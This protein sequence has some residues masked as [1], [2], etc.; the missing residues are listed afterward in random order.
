MEPRQPMSTDSNQKTQQLHAERAPRPDT[1]SPADR[2][3]ELFVAV[4]SGPVFADSKTF[5][6]CAPVGEPAAILQAYR[7][8]FRRPDF[9]LAAFVDRHFDVTHP[10]KSEYQSEPGQGLCAHIDSLWPVLTRDPRQHAANASMLHLPEP[11]VVPGG[12]FGEMYYWDSYFTMV[13]LAA[14]E[15]TDL[16][17]AMLTNFSYLID[18]YGHVPNGTRSYYLSRS[19][20][21]VFALMLELAEQHGVG[22]AANHRAQ[23]QQE[24]AYWMAGSSE[25]SNLAEIADGQATRRVVRLPNGLQ[26]NRYWDDRDTPREESWIEDV[27]TAQSCTRDA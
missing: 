2:Y 13:G 24:H 15:R 9:E 12:R 21:P 26:L 20:P 5:V 8:Q 27:S 11:Y 23:L 6:D 19:Q 4:Q 10:P 16:L 25:L 3:Q 22:R 1:I 17:C 18:T 7:D 14:S